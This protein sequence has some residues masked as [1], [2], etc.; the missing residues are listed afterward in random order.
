MSFTYDITTDRGKVRFLSTDTDST[1][2][3]FED[4]EV[5]AVI[6]LQ[7][8]NLYA[9]A[10]LLCETW[11]RSRSKLSKMVRASDG[12]ITQRYSM[13]E[14]LD[15]AR[16]LREAALNGALVTDTLSVAT[17]NEMLDSYRPEWR[18]VDDLPVVE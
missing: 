15:L 17:P 7:P 10:A 4:A 6:S 14:L 16:S 5:D 11:A 3:V 8:S 2:Y 9:A 12:T 1:S 18:S 13:Q